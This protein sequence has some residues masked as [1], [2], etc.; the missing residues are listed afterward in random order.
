MR[1][2]LKMVPWDGSLTQALF[3]ENLHDSDFSEKACTLLASSQ[4]DEWVLLWICIVA[5]HYKEQV[6][7]GT[8]LAI[9]WLGLCASTAGGAG[10]IPVGELRSHRPLGQK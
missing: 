4:R 5:S 9:Q 6:K 8:F 1:D 3:L 10:S 7:S 2:A